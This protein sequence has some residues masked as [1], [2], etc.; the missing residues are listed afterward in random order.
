MRTCQCLIS[1]FSVERLARAIRPTS[2]CSSCVFKYV[3]VTHILGETMLQAHMLAVNTLFEKLFVRVLTSH[4]P[5]AGFDSRPRH[6]S[7]GTSSLRQR[8]PWS[9]LIIVVTP[10]W[11]VLLDSEYAN[12]PVPVINIQGWTTCKSYS[13]YILVQLIFVFMN[14]R[15][16]PCCRLIFTVD[17]LNS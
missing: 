14:V 3:R 8:W 1:I 6:V 16:K 9:S 2:W 10:T 7:L 17:V 4:C 12:L 13:A 15:E 11:S 5:E